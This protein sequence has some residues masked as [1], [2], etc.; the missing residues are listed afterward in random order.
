MDDKNPPLMLPNGNIYSEKVCEVETE[1]KRKKK[2]EKYKNQEVDGT[3]IPHL[4][5]FLYSQALDNMLATQGHILD[6]RT[7]QRY[8][9][10]QTKRVFIM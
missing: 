9:A 1:R 10:N 4:F 6:P 5:A 8:E 3:R 7:S 2:K